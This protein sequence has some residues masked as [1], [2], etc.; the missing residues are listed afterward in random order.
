LS[1][2]INTWTIQGLSWQQLLEAAAEVV[3]VQ[4]VVL[5]EKWHV[6]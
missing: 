6:Y 5:V 3:L 1:A 2:N 4:V